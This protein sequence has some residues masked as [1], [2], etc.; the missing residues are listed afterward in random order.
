MAHGLLPFVLT[1]LHAFEDG[2]TGFFGVGDGEF[3][4]R[5]E[6]GKDF[7]DR[8]FAGGAVGQWFGGKGAAEHKFSAADFAVSFTEFVFVQRR[9]RK[10]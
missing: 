7:A 9:V 5:V 1:F 10:S 8:F 6:G 4:G 3:F 2:E